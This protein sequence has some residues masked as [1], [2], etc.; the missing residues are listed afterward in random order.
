MALC[1]TL[2]CS[3]SINILSGINGVEAQ[4]IIMSLGFMCIDI[5]D[6]RIDILPGLIVST[7]ILSLV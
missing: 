5:I 2:F 4:V 7:S 1:C 6:G 3:N